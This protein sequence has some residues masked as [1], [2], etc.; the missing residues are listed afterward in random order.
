M[1][2]IWKD[3]GST[4]SWDHF[5]WDEQVVPVKT[6]MKNV[7]NPTIGKSDPVVLQITDTL[8]AGATGKTE[9]ANAPVTLVELGD[10]RDAAAD[11]L[12]AEA[13]ARENWLAK[14][15]AR[16]EA[17]GILRTSVKRYALHANSV[18]MADK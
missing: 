10:Q 16:I 2:L 15:V 5:S 9:L 13:Q 1:I 3:D 12:T 7:K 14:R 6:T 11:A 17:F 18:Y 8:I 4:M